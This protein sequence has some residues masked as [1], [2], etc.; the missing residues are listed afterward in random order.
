MKFLKFIHEGIFKDGFINDNKVST[1]NL[2]ILDAITVYKEFNDISNFISGTYSFE[3]IEIIKPVEPKKV[4]C[5]GLNFL[6]HAKELKMD[7]PK[8]PPIFIK[9]SSSVIGPN[10]G[11]VFPDMAEELDF[12]AELAVVILKKAKNILKKDV[13]EYI[14]GF[15][16]LNDVT[17]RDLQRVDSQWTRAKGFDTFCPI[18][19]V[20]ETDFNYKNEKISSILN[21]DIKQSSTLDNMI[22]GPEHLIEFV[23]SIMTLYPGDIIALGTP[24]G[25][26]NMQKGDTIEIEITGIGTLENKVI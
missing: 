12:E 13:P 18:G 11:I 23:S 8:T 10:E 17:A 1:L 21:G 20:I 3:D 24:P 6:D 2:N 26:G 7:I 14:A 25:I 19:P 9:P 5:V 16:C 15:T 4:V 22:F